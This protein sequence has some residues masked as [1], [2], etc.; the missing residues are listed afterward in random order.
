MVSNKQVLFTKIPTGYP[1]PNEHMQVKEST[2]D[3]DAPLAKG[4]FILKQLVFSVDPY[5]RG[6]MRDASVKSYAPAF[7]IDKPMT[8]DTMGVVVKSNHPDYKVDD[9]VY[10]RTAQGSFE[11][12]TLV[13]AEYAKKAYLVRN[14]AKENGLPLR[15]YVGVLAMPGMTAYYGLNKIGKPKKGETLYVSAAAGA[16]GQLVGQFG[17]ALGLYVVGS[18]GTEEK[19]EYLKSLGFDAA[20][21]YKNGSIDENLGKHCPNGIDI[22]YENVGGEMLDAVLKHANLYARVIA[23][24]MISQYNIA[25]PEPIYNLMNVVT[26]RITIE[27]FII[28]DHYDF[29]EE[30]LKEVTP[31]LVDGRVKYREDIAKGIDQTPQ[32]LCNV[33]RGVNFGKQVIEIADL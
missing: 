19:V 33:L 25:K 20:F 10:G 4:E 24:G 15:H 26:K 7:P 9:L 18:A 16:V 30:F 11:E 12:Y 31:M 22:Y 6:R 8:G 17:K 3:L 29:E 21:N 1:E 13:T 23:C 27:G 5:M 32:A 14:D 28:M 2:I